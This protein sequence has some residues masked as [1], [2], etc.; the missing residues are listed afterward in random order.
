VGHGVLLLVQQ[1]AVVVGDVDGAWV[2]L[3]S[4]P[5]LAPELAEE[6]LCEGEPEV[7]PE[8][9]IGGLVPGYSNDMSL[10]N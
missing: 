6:L 1:A 10:L 9:F 2:E 8:S 4:S 7:P 5:N 3:S